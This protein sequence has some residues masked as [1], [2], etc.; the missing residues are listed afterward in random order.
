M[1]KP[2]RLIFVSLFK[3]L[4][5]KYLKGYNKPLSINQKIMK[6][7][8]II[9]AILFAFASCNNSTSTER[10]DTDS[11]SVDSGENPS[12]LHPTG[13]ETNGVDT[14]RAGTMTQ[15]SDNGSGSG[16]HT[17]PTGKADS[18]K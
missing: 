8:L 13:P 14:A 18:T 2:P 3:N 16:S 12:T 6:R 10:H 1:V 5:A 9:S 7:I 15:G 17:N 4:L 11:T